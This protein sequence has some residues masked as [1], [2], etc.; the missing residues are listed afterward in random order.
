M[1]DREID[2]SI[3]DVLS[4]HDLTYLSILGSGGEG[5]VLLCHS[6]RRS[7]DFAVKVSSRTEGLSQEVGALQSIFSPNVIYIYEVFAEG[8]FAFLVMEYCPGGSLMDL[9]RNE[10]RLPRER[11]YS[12]CKEIADALF[13]CHE[14]GIAHLD[15]KPQNVLFDK[16]GRAK[17]TDFGCAQTLSK[18]SDAQQFRG[19]GAFMS[20]EIWKHQ[21]YDPFK[22]DVWSLGVT[23]H[24]MA[25]GALPWEFRSAAYVRAM[26]NGLE[27]TNHTMPSTFLRILHKM[28]IADPL[29]RATLEE[30]RSL[31]SGKVSIKASLS[32]RRFGRSGQDSAGIIRTQTLSG[33]TVLGLVQ[34]SGGGH[35]I[36]RHKSDV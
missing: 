23:F 7:E 24:M 11:L 15:I 9:I 30:V 19:S 33:M 28:L 1:Y 21:R 27:A 8:E 13:A 36:R 29:A 4:N 26:D 16:H 31:L 32:V 22:A 20:P 35:L 34:P 5:Q 6:E 10:G 25:T 18:S 3:V 2:P 14:T 17:L 12:L